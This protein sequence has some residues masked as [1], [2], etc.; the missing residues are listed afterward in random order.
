MDVAGNNHSVV[1]ALGP[2]AGRI[3]EQGS[4]LFLFQ[5]EAAPVLLARADPKV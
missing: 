4:L 1:A 5:L 2:V 3:Q